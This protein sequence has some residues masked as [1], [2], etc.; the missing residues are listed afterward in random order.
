MD[1][2]NL[3]KKELIALVNKLQNK[4][5]QCGHENTLSENRHSDFF[6][7]APDMFFSIH[8]D[9]RVLSV[10]AFGAKNLGYFEEELIG[11][12]VWKVVYK[13]DLSRIK[14]RI[15]EILQKKI[16]KGELEFRK[17]RKDGS[18]IFVHEHTQ[19]IFN[20]DKSI[21]ELLIICRDITKRKEIENVLKL[22]EEKY[23]SLANNL[24]VG[25]YRSSNDLSGHFIEANPAL[26]KMLG[27]RNKA[28]LLKM[29]ISDLYA[30][31]EGRKKFID[32]IR[33]KG[34]V[35]N[36]ELALLKKD[37]TEINCKISTVLIKD[38]EGKGIYYDGII[39]DISNLKYAEKSIDKQKEFL[40]SI[41]ES[42][43]HP[44][45][46]INVDDYSVEVANSAAGKYIKKGEGTCYA[47]THNNNVPCH[48]T[49]EVCP[50]AEIKKT[51]KPFSVEHIHLDKNGNERFYEVNA[52]P[53]FDDNHKLKQI[54]EYTIDIT[55]RKNSEKILQH[56]EEQY[57]ILFQMAPIGIVIEGKDGII[58]D[59]NPAYCETVGYNIEELIGRHI[60][61]LTHPENKKN[62]E[63]NIKRILKGSILKH[64]EKSINKN[65]SILYT[66]LHEKRIE[67]P[68]GHPA[69]L[70][71]ARDITKQ[72]EEQDKLIEQ[73]RK[74]R[75]IFNAFPDIYF[76]S[77]ISGIVKEISPSVEKLT[78]FSV[79]EVIGKHS[80]EFYYSGKDWKNIQKAFEGSQE[81]KDFNTRIKTK[82]GGY[83]HC[84]FSARVNIN[85]QN[86]PIEIEGVLRDITE[87]EK[88]EL[89]IRKLSE[90]VEQSPVIVVI[91]DLDGTIEY[92]N[93]KFCEVTGYCFEEAIGKN[94]KILKSGK[95][96]S[97]TFTSLWETITS[98]KEWYGEFLNRKKNGEL[99]WESAYIFPLKDESGKITRFIAQ[100]EDISTRKKMEQDLIDARDK[101]EES[102]K[103]KSAFLANMSHEIRTPM[104]AILGFSQLLSEPETSP[105]EQNHYIG[106]IQN[107]GN[108]LLALI[109]DIIDISKVEAGQIKIFKSDYFL[110]N[111]L[112][113]LY[114]SFSEFLKTKEKKKKLQLKYSRVK[115]ADKA[116]IFTDI[117][118]FKQIFINLLNNAIKFTDSGTVEFGFSIEKSEGKNVFGFYV[119]DTGIGIENDKL[120]IIFNSFRQANDSN[121]RL[122]G[123]TGLGL[124]ITKRMVE[125]LGG[126]INVSSKRGKGSTFSFTLP[127]RNENSAISFI[128]NKQKKDSPLKRNIKWNDKALLIVEDDDQGFFF[129]EKVF[130]N[131]GIKITRAITGREAVNQCKRNPFDIV[132]MDIQ[133][134]EMDG[135]EATKLIK[136]SKPEIPIIAQTAYALSGEKEKCM[137]AGCDD[138]ISKPIDISELMAKMKFLLE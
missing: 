87:R 73:E 52:F 100:K 25:L 134:P 76:K 90:V 89:E 35:K 94:P 40:Y 45:Y 122:Y 22:E 130:K 58:F 137:N 11:Q 15:H 24:N 111:I 83:I 13:D 64:V 121:T 42:I 31:P 78:G 120:D 21:K 2:N 123:G 118:R 81:I 16:A 19:L 48:E 79:Q 55:N 108:D 74:F 70:C 18:V 124:A 8:P 56:R 104:N 34:F 20:S 93:P 26:V 110:D 102:D 125:L 99:Y 47:L 101:A 27:Y 5:E 43:T 39:E 65:G 91:T 98:G 28:D 77:N 95:T 80:K 68:N 46:V 54:I 96:P 29:N 12:E 127:I 57:R 44:F 86:N 9:G 41:L 135:L 50:I 119:S 23:R 53:V 4:L 113:E 1:F 10:N 136:K 6:D 109:D 63:K 116:I 112:S 114:T 69:I 67:L 71:F 115:N 72:K 138:Y 84:S 92:V 32:T 62:V 107:S 66:E 33:K 131:T 37:N 30:E 88:A 132:L 126:Q 105:D 117:D 59:A 3:S 85:K 128:G 38:E 133:L 17:V 97:E 129:F 51:G 49:N 14:K 103:L 75:D 60:S 7:N 106:L 36:M 82:S 61:I